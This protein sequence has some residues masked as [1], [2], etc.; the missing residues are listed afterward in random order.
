[1]PNVDDKLEEQL[2]ARIAY[3]KEQLASLSQTQHS[4]IKAKRYL[5]DELHKA[6]LAQLEK[7]I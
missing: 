2:A 5:E 3:L 6:K 1:M 7:I 4:L